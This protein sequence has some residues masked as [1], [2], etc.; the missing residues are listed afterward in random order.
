MLPNAPDSELCSDPNPLSAALLNHQLIHVEAYITHVDLVLSNE[1]VYKLTA[2]TVDAL[3][4]YH[5]DV[6]C[7]NAKA[8]TYDWPEKEQACERLHEE[9]ASAVKKFVY[10]TRCSMLAELDGNGGGELLCAESEKVKNDIMGLLKP[11]LPPLPSVADA[12]WSSPLLP[13]SPTDDSV[14]CA[15]TQS[16]SSALVEPWSVAPASA[17]S[18]TSL[19]ASMGLSQPATS[20]N[21]LSAGLD[22]LFDQALT[23]APLPSMLGQNEFVHDSATVG[24]AD[25]F[26]EL[27]REMYL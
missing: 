6:H 20:F 23:M 18:N 10:R 12:A 5:R 25:L 22:W 15:P 27:D 8:S 17:D 16:F 7:A 13:V 21:Q 9:F 14:W 19:W 3:I 24:D 11:L 2:D 26:L 1:V 4:A